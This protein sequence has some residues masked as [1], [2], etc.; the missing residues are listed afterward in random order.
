MGETGDDHREVL[1]DV[2]TPTRAQALET[3]TSPPSLLQL[4]LLNML[5]TM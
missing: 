2:V 5:V 1:S 4:Q 3:L